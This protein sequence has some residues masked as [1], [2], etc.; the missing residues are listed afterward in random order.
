M[1]EQG[2]R[3][4]AGAR[5]SPVARVLGPTLWFYAKAMGV[6]LR[7]RR[8]A[9]KGA[10]TP[11]TVVIRSEEIIRAVEACGGTVIID[12]LSVLYQT[13]GPVV[14]VS[15]HMSTLETFLL[16]SIVGTVKRLDYIVK[17]GLL[18]HPVF[19]PIMR[20]CDPI[21][22]TRRDPREDLKTVLEQGTARLAAGRSIGLFPQ[23]TRAMTFNPAHFN[24][25]GEKLA[26]RAGVPLVPMAVRTDFWGI[27][28][29]LKEMGRVRPEIPVRVRLGAPLAVTRATARD[30][31]RA[32]VD[33][34]TSTLT[35]WGVPCANRG[36]GATADDGH[37]PAV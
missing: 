17:E 15:N 9:L 23:T 30:V 34:L 24:S 36:E 31:H 12:D 32:V 7:E 29:V 5:P 26:Q 2:Y 4:P 35:E 11:T 20:A 8:L 10:S 3:T 33:F 6:V 22:V 25:L 19:G 28:R 18:T 1:T 16:P 14:V 37:A 27:G 13:P 21:A